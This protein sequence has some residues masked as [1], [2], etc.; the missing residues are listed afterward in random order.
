MFLLINAKKKLSTHY[1]TI[2]LTFLS[3]LRH[4]L[5]TDGRDGRCCGADAGFH[6]NAGSSEDTRS[7]WLLEILSAV[8]LFALVCLKTGFILSV[9]E[10]LKW[11]A[12]TEW[13]AC[14][15]LLNITSWGWLFDRNSN[16]K[17]TQK[18]MNYLMQ[19][20]W[21]YITVFIAQNLYRSIKQNICKLLTI[22]PSLSW[23]KA[24]CCVC[25]ER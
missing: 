2:P 10:E 19:S 5:Q 6:G 22:S 13:N 16:I 7:G 11:R 24:Q 23:T 9:S 21:Q 14:G 18:I 8:L 20:N 3:D 15:L 1:K 4:D 12:Q 17:Q 25:E